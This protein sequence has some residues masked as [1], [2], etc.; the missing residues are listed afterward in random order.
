[1]GAVCLP[2]RIVVGW[3]V[4]FWFDAASGA[5]LNRCTTS[6]PPG[7]TTRRSSACAD[8]VLR[9]L[10]HVNHSGDLQPERRV[11]KFNR[12]DNAIQHLRTSGE[13]IKRNQYMYMGTI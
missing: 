4:F 10:H 9:S 1:M 13:M 7:R 5:V 6:A 12:V 11:Y 8:W 3:V 2:G